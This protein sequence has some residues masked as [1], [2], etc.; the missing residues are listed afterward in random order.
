MTGPVKPIIDNKERFV[1]F[2]DS[3]FGK[4]EKRISVDA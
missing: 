3:S 4:T 1:G 2:V